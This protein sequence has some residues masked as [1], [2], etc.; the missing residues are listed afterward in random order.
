MTLIAPG[1]PSI[2]SKIH[3]YTDRFEEL[4]AF[5]EASAVD[6][7][8]LGIPRRLVFFKLLRARVIKEA[9]NSRFYLD[10]ER[11]VSY[12]RKRRWRAAIIIILA[13]IV[14]TVLILADLHLI[15]VPYLK[16]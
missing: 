14:A 15:K 16:F 11:L 10:R 7:Q 5:D 12:N 3:E 9:E 1:T 6:I 13:V 8:T 4:R 2:A